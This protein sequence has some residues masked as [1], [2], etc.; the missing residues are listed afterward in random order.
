M[1]IYWV[2]PMGSTDGDL[3][4]GEEES[5]RLFCFPLLPRGAS[6]AVSVSPHCFLLPLYEP[7]V[8]AATVIC[9]YTLESDKQTHPLVFPI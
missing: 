4:T 3:R 1:P 8:V 7:A 9:P 6:L 5:T 2:C